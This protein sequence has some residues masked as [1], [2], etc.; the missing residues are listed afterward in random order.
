MYKK[1][2]NKSE[3]LL[4][5]LV[6]FLIVPNSNSITFIYNYVIIYLKKGGLIMFLLMSISLIIIMVACLIVSFILKYK[7]KI[8]KPQ[9]NNTNTLQPKFLRYTFIILAIFA[10]LFILKSYKYLLLVTFISKVIDSVYLIIFLEKD[11]TR[12]HVIIDF[13][14]LT[15]G[16]IYIAASFLG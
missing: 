7:F 13:I 4:D 15:Y 12:Y 16:S 10:F 2:N 11:K 9:Y 14:F 6:I 5:E 3:I 1:E 8:P